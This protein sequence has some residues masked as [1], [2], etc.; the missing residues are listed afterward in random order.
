M[1][2]EFKV[3]FSD[4]EERVVLITEASISAAAHNLGPKRLAKLIY[5]VIRGETIDVEDAADGNG[6]SF[7]AYMELFQGFD[8][9]PI[10]R[11]K[12]IE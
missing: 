9:S 1:G 8:L 4:G 10:I 3:H 7:T 5:Q 11:A 6:I 12:T 2:K